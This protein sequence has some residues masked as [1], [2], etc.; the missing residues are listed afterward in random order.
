MVYSGCHGKTFNCTSD[1]FM[2]AEFIHLRCDILFVVSGGVQQLVGAKTL[3][4]G[5]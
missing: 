5:T 4:P 2:C 3:I 1:L